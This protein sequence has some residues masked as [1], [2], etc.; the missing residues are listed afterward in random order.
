MPRCYYL[1]NVKRLRPRERRSSDR[2]KWPKFWRHVCHNLRATNDRISPARRTRSAAT[3]IRSTECSNIFNYFY[4]ALEFGTVQPLVDEIQP[5]FGP[6]RQSNSSRRSILC[7]DLTARNRIATFWSWRIE[8]EKSRQVN[9]LAR[10]KLKW[11]FTWVVQK[12]ILRR[13]I[14]VPQRVLKVSQ[15]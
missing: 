2:W 3:G 4:Q 7:A 8:A 9:S 14:N 12:S 13:I 6:N 15:A 10:Q 5:A 1:W 11:I